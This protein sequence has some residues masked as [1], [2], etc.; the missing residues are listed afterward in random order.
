[1][2]IQALIQFY[3]SPLGKRV[4]KTLPQVAQESEQLGVQ[5]QQK[6]AMNVLQDMS[7]DYPELKQMLRP[8]GAAPDESPAP[9][10]APAPEAPPTPKPAPAP[11]SN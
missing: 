9:G 10:K 5:M 7:A 11:P 8:Q 3:E 4:V 1:D 2:D 6:G